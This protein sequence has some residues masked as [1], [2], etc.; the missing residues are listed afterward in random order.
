MDSFGLEESSSSTASVVGGAMG[1]A[2]A[3]EASAKPKLNMSPEEVARRVVSIL[4][5]TEI[6]WDLISYKLKLQLF[7]Y[8][9]EGRPF[10]RFLDTS[11]TFVSIEAS[12]RAP[13]AEWP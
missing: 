1:G 11:P 9:L 3:T 7:F 5:F 10:R 8:F 4:S 6:Y 13:A 12:G 2:E